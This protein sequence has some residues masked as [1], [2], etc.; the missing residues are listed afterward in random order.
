MS[1]RVLI[2]DD[3]RVMR[4]I[5]LRALR[6]AGIGHIDVGE[7]ADGAEGLAM[8]ES[9]APDLILSDWNMPKVNG[10]EFLT[11]LRAASNWTSFGFITSEAHPSFK[12]EAIAAG[13]NFLL[14]KPFNSEQISSMLWAVRS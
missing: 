3:S 13:A 5:I 1:V 14:T 9:F 2:V 12:Y 10:L 4:M 8:V 6:Q 11:A 7:A